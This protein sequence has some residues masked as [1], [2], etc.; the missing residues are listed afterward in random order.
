MRYHVARLSLTDVSQTA[1]ARNSP[2]LQII[3]PRSPRLPLSQVQ[4]LCCCCTKPRGV[5]YSQTKCPRTHMYLTYTHLNCQP[6]RLNPKRSHSE[7]GPAGKLNNICA[8]PTNSLSCPDT[9]KLYWLAVPRRDV[10]PTYTRIVHESTTVVK[11]C[12]II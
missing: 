1:C 4:L 2:E 12:W 7:A 9:L 6:T 10:Q 11:V 5:T 3:P 8:S